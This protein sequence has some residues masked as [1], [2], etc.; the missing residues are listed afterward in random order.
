MPGHRI[1]LLLLAGVLA[2]S[3]K[4]VIETGDTHSTPLNFS[5]V[6]PHLAYYNNESECGTGAVVPWA[7][8]LWVVTYG[9]HLPYGS[10]DKLYEID[11][12][13]RVVI[14]PE[15]VGGTPA[16]RMIHRESNQLFIGPYAIDSIRKVRVIPYQ[17]AP[18]R[19]TG[20][21][22]HLTD[23]S[24]KLYIATM[25]EG[26]YELDVNTLQTTMIHEDGNVKT[27]KG[28]DI[29]VN[30][31]GSLLPGAHGKGAYSGQGVLVYSNNGEAIPEAL[32]KFDIESGA[33]AEWNGREWKV[34]RRNQFVEV[35]G[36]GG[37]YGNDN[38]E[39]GPIWATGWDHKSVLLGVRDNGTWSFFRLPK[40][41][42][43][44][45][46]AHG[47][48]TEWPRIRDIGTTARPD[49]LM[50]MHGMFWR[51]P[52]T[53]SSGDAKGIRPRSAYLK[54]IGD[55]AR[56]NN[57][58]VFGCDDS[59]QKEFLNTRKVKGTI[60]GPGQ[61]NSNL[62]FTPLQLPDALGPVTAAG[63]VW[64]D[65]DISASQPSEPFLF[66]GWPYR[67]A[68]ISN[69][70]SPTRF[71][72]ETAENGNGPWRELKTVTVA[73]DESVNVSFEQA[74]TGEWIRAVA[75]QHTRGTIHFSFSDKDER[76]TRH[77]RIFNGLAPVTDERAMGGLLYGLGD[78]RRA[79]GMNAMKFE[80]K[81]MLETGYYELTPEMK[82]VKKDDPGTQ[83]LIREKFAVPGNVV[84]IDAAS[85]L[86]TDDAGR[87]WRLPLGDDEFTDLT[88]SAF[89]RIAREVAT[90]RDLFNC[91][92]TFY[93][94]PAENADGFAKIRP[95]ASHA[96]RIHDYASY[97]GMLIV[98]GIDPAIREDNPHLIVSDDGDA[99]VWAGVIDD[100]W[101]IGKPI[102]RGGP[103][104]DTKVKKG[105]PSDPYLIGFYD[106]RKLSLS[107]NL[108]EPVT[109]LIEAEP[110]GHGPWM[111]YRQFTVE[112][113]KVI[114]YEFP[115]DFQSRWIR[116]TTDKD[117]TVTAWLIYD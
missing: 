7:D 112:P 67:T 101:K 62:W 57:R 37:I 90:E 56:W 29:S 15:S 92:G 104:K 33:L 21:A 47:W 22:R 117:A 40:A 65:E 24:N 8:R 16:N 111:K 35:T 54:V 25:E 100:L 78:D 39:T 106:R 20:L 60:S 26:F 81:K 45:D 58:L 82:L 3:C 89:L 72:F 6:Y 27:E 61:S 36:P 5:G 103:W 51:F 55:F 18:G 28:D 96:F 12:S 23:P 48:N 64:L 34:V 53:F 84:T 59:A 9:P 116:F 19:Y 97:R 17:D 75:D 94:L 32:K 85:V 114:D 77:D 50:T 108:E 11:T 13:L 2:F 107:H 30:Q 87:R 70:G 80:N 71:R 1:L 83:S 68:W 41:S 4:P 43:S 79:L 88:N 49:Y 73:A 69:E 74:T 98:T 31:P 95:I 93:E 102:G 91:H 10:S 113:G 110:V 86:I 66:A 42:H 44:Y 14:R 38:P 76:G 115:S 105:E 109:F 46:G 63:A 52:A 99:S